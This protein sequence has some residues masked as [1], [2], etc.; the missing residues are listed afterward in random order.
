MHKV[1][2]RSLSDDCHCTWSFYQSSIVVGTVTDAL[3]S[4]Y[5]DPVSKMK[6]KCG[7]AEHLAVGLMTVLIDMPYDIIVVKYSHWIWH[8][9]DP[10]VG[11]YRIA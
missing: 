6:L 7:Y 11:N 1:C 9:T 5:V 10:N 8:D 2:S 4:V 3:L